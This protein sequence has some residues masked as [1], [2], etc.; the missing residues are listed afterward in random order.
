M[1]ADDLVLSVE[2]ERVIKPGIFALDAFLGRVLEILP[3]IGGVE[4]GLGRN[5]ADKEACT[6]KSGILLDNRGFQPILPGADGSRIST[7][8]TTDDD[9]VICHFSSV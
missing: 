4:Q 5:A 2:D 9:Q 8:T 6:S 7:G 1:L 3:D